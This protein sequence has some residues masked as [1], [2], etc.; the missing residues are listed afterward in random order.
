MRQLKE[1]VIYKIIESKQTLEGVRYCSYG[2]AV[3]PKSDNSAPAWLSVDD[4]TTDKAR[5]EELIRQC[6]LLNL[7]PIH[8]HDVIEDFL[9]K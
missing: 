9:Q 1:D 7:S 6:N 8:L 3:Y 2:I 4:I 5:L